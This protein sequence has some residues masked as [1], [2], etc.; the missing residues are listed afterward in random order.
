VVLEVLCC[1]E[2]AA[3]L[4]CVEEEVVEEMI[5]WEKHQQHEEVVEKQGSLEE[6]I[7]YSLARSSIRDERPHAASPCLPL[8]IRTEGRRPIAHTV[9]SSGQRVALQC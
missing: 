7:G 1:G 3:S 5:G 4:L 8:P 2:H 6:E 9:H